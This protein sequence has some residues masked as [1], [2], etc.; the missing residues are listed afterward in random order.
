M[1]PFSQSEAEAFWYAAPHLSKEHQQALAQLR[2]ELQTRGCL[3]PTVDDDPSLLRFLKARGWSVERA[4]KMYQVIVC[5]VRGALR[6]GREWQCMHTREQPRKTCAIGWRSLAAARQAQL[7]HSGHNHVSV[8][9]HSSASHS[10]LDLKQCL[11][12]CLRTCRPWRSGAK[13]R[14]WTR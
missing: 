9:R 3:A 12:L 7:A 11:C 8:L 10:A 6:K 1:V 13:P 2:S 5:A 4:A 14:A